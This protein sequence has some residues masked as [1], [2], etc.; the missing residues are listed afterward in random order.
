MKPN[1]ANA[2]LHELSHSLSTVL[3]VATR[4]GSLA[5]KPTRKPARG[6]VNAAVVATAEPVHADGRVALMAQLSPGAAVVVVVVR[7]ARHGAV[8]VDDER[9]RTHRHA[10]P[11]TLQP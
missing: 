5:T 7:A 8:S 4:P 2:A 9:N 3:I 10:R 6:L 1:A 11:A